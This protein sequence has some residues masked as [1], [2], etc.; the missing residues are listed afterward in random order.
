VAC[1]RAGIEPSRDRYY[2]FSIPVVSRLAPG[3]ALW[4]ARH[5]EALDDTKPFAWLGAGYL[6]MVHRTKEE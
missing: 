6:L 5:L 4:L 1:R 3:P 2:D